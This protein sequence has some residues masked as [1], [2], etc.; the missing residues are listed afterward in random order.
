MDFLLKAKDVLFLTQGGAEILH[1]FL[2]GR[3][4]ERLL[5]H[6]TPFCSAF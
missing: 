4:L 6:S 3:L 1:Q 5:I 2:G